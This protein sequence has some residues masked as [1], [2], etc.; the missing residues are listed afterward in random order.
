MPVVGVVEHDH[1]AAAG[2]RVG[3]PQREIVGLRAAVDEEAHV[4]RVRERRREPARVVDHRPVQV[5]RVGVEHLHL[6]LPGGDHPR[7]AVADVRDVV[8]QIEEGAALV[9]EQIRALAADDLQRLV[10]GERERAAHDRPPR[11]ARCP[12]AALRADDAAR[13]A[14]QQVRVGA[15]AAVEVGLL[16][17][18]D[19]LEIAD[20]IGE[21]L[22]VDVRLPAAVD[23][24]R[25]E[26]GDLARPA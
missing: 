18:R 19:A 16:G 7:V 23:L 25:A 3:E 5:A 10:V 26:R 13:E 14:E 20:Q 2:V 12:A 17:Q 4:Q 1:V 24:G 9:V 21:E 22:E 8:D 6:A 11:A 15:D